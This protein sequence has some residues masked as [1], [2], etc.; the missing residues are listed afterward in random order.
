MEILGMNEGGSQRENFLEGQSS[1]NLW[2]VKE[3]DGGELS[4]LVSELQMMLGREEQSRRKLGEELEGA[5]TKLEEER[6]KG[7]VLGNRAAELEAS[8]VALVTELERALRGEAEAV[9][10]AARYERRVSDT[11]LVFGQGGSE[12]A[13]D[14]EAL[15]GLITEL[16]KEVESL[17]REKSRL[18]REL[19][20]EKHRAA[21]AEAEALQVTE[22]LREGQAKMKVRLE[23]ATERH[24]N[25]LEFVEN[26]RR[27]RLLLED[28]RQAEAEEI[29]RAKDT[30]IAA[31]EKELSKFKSQRKFK[32]D[33][34]LLSPDLNKH[35][36]ANEAEK[37]NGLEGLE[38]LEG[39]EELEGF[40]VL[41][42]LDGLEGLEGTHGAKE[43][44]GVKDKEDLKELDRTEGVDG[45]KGDLIVLVSE[46][47]SKTVEIATLRDAL[48]RSGDS[49]DSADQLRAKQLEAELR[50][51]EEAL[52]LEHQTWERKV[53]ELHDELIKVKSKF[54][55]QILEKDEAIVRLRAKLRKSEAAL[56]LYEQQIKEFNSR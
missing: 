43:A 7:R 41:E 44:Q 55:E 28:Q 49:P 40:E 29:V 2:E 9:E 46:L 18:S 22:E 31:L 27:S 36:G 3:V 10:R 42:V 37:L 8:N 21:E 56:S 33:D 32:A 48:A 34:H 4:R 53:E 12:K 23:E 45:T 47:N 54:S 17:T 11:S 15:Q 13:E 25:L 50:R 35:E 20:E 26:Q 1:R 5:G 16:R 51:C 52:K 19:E 30:R 24:R 38:R 14:S 39:L 6:A